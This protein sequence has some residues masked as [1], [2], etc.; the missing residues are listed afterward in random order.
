[1]LSNLVFRLISHPESQDMDW[2]IKHLKLMMKYA[3]FVPQPEDGVQISSELS[4]EIIEL[5]AR[6]QRFRSLR[7]KKICEM[8]IE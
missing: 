7:H 1:M 6:L 2:K 5:I 4:G 8:E 3:V